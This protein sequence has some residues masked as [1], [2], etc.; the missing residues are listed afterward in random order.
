[1]DKTTCK[2]R[3]TQASFRCLFQIIVRVT[4]D[5]VRE[6]IF[7]VW[8]RDED[9]SNQKGLTVTEIVDQA[10]A[11][12]IKGMYIQGEN[13]AMSDPD[14]EH[15]RDAFANLQHLVVQDYLFN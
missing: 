8:G 2:G 7:S 9:W 4:D 13:P 1:M 15:A 5:A 11:G 14:V 6:N 10:Y 3:R 12:N